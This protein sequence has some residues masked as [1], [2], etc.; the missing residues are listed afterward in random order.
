[1]KKF[2]L[3]LVCI[4]MSTGF[5]CMDKSNQ[6]KHVQKRFLVLY[7]QLTSKGENVCFLCL[8]EIDEKSKDNVKLF[9][10]QK[11]FHLEC[12][13]N[14]ID[15]KLKNGPV[16]LACPYCSIAICKECKEPM[17]IYCRNKILKKRTA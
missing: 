1:M 12:L 4:S 11:I 2:I 7:R 3:L 13:K 6:E 17:C 10:C 5:F 15:E 16:L 8:K 9:C 14:W